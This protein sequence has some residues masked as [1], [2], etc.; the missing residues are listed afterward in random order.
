VS[1]SYP[2]KSDGLIYHERITPQLFPLRINHTIKDQITKEGLSGY[3]LI[4]LDL[5]VSS[6]TD[7]GEDISILKFIRS[8]DVQQSVSTTKQEGNET[9]HPTNRELNSQ[10]LVECLEKSFTWKQIFGPTQR[11]VLVISIYRHIHSRS[12]AEPGQADQ[13][14]GK[15]QITGFS[16]HKHTAQLLVKGSALPRIQSIMNSK[17]RRSEGLKLLL[18]RWPILLPLNKSLGPIV[19]HV[20]RVWLINR[21]DQ[22]LE[23]GSISNSDNCVWASTVESRGGAISSS[24]APVTSIRCNKPIIRLTTI[25]EERLKRIRDKENKIVEQEN[26]LKNDENVT[27]EKSTPP[28]TASTYGRASEKDGKLNKRISMIK[29]TTKLELQKSPDTGDTSMSITDINNLLIRPEKCYNLLLETLMSSSIP[30]CRSHYCQLHEMESAKL[31]KEK[32]LSHRLMK[33]GKLPKAAQHMTVEECQ[34]E[35]EYR[36]SVEPS[37]MLHH[38]IEGLRNDEYSN[39]DGAFQQERR[40]INEKWLE[41]VKLRKETSEGLVSGSSQRRNSQG[42]GG[43][44]PQRGSI[45]LNK[46]EQELYRTEA[47][48]TQLQIAKARSDK[49][50]KS[51]KLAIQEQKI[52]KQREEDI[53]RLSGIVKILND[54]RKNF[55][56]DPLKYTG[57]LRNAVIEYI[58]LFEQGGMSDMFN[59]LA[60]LLRLMTRVLKS[61]VMKGKATKEEKE[62]LAVFLKQTKELSQ[63]RDKPQSDPTNGTKPY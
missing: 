55:P 21:E 61:S 45:L 41:K 37:I 46:R 35:L 5:T 50:S 4:P 56:Q 51:Q 49:F 7:F 57:G 60:D 42:D 52:K 59:T 8:S 39:K 19:E 25:A 29:A 15:Y 31:N 18:L 13:P 34:K 20:E 47:M 38:S 3:L 40:R 43:G 23:L 54:E 44:G 9:N 24:V 27:A 62:M 14:Y 12:T 11:P 58:L 1:V 33:V 2:N 36:Q 10:L 26:Q 16:G 30:Y 17:C 63:I 32:L 48:V 53:N 6:K 28:P 22:I